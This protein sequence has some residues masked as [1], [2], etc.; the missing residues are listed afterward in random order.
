MGMMPGWDQT[1]TLSCYCSPLR[2]V[3]HN[4]LYKQ[5]ET[6][7]KMNTHTH[8]QNKQNKTKQ[9]NEE[10]ATPKKT[11]RNN[12]TQQKQNTKQKRILVTKTHT[13]TKTKHL[14][15]LTSAER[16]EIIVN[17]KTINTHI[18]TLNAMMGRSLSLS[19]WFFFFIYSFFSYITRFFE[20]ITGRAVQART[21]TFAI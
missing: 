12:Q 17:K 20:I 14:R 3:M 21:L 1:H 4:S 8:I 16:I 6:T 18:Y 9:T 5:H 7:K 13:Q 15:A 11:A 2:R 19:V 10:R